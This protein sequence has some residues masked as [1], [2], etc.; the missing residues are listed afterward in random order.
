MVQKERA[1]S[2]L[3]RWAQYMTVDLRAM[4]GRVVSARL[5]LCSCDGSLAN[6]YQHGQYYPITDILLLTYMSTD[7]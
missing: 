7:R 2:G 5:Q 1:G 3:I 4:G 6:I